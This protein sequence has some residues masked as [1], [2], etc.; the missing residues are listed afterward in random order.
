MT[1]RFPDDAAA[2]GQGRGGQGAGGAARLDGGGE[3]AV[4]TLELPRSRAAGRRTGAVLTQTPEGLYK[5]VLTDP[6]LPAPRPTAECKVLAPPGEMDQLRMNQT[7]MERAAEK[8]HGGFYTV[9]NADDAAQ[10]KNLRADARVRL[11]APSGSAWMF[12]AFPVFFL[13]ALLAL[14]T[15]WVLR[16]Q[17]NLV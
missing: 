16:K 8:T 3:P 13:M 5:F 7:E 1:V 6:S 12:W 10:D 9:A 17:R 15:E 14:T 4:R 2:A 11:Q